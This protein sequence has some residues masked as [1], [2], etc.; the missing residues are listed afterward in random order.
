MTRALVNSHWIFCSI[1]TVKTRKRQN[2]DIL[3]LFLLFSTTFVYFLLPWASIYV[4]FLIIIFRCLCSPTLYSFVVSVKY[5]PPIKWQTKSFLI[6]KHDIFDDINVLNIVKFSTSLARKF[7]F[8]FLGE[9]K[10]NFFFV[11]CSSWE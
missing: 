4:L 5:F 6:F 8:A 2:S 11:Y 10:K 3:E 9:R 7:R 1:G